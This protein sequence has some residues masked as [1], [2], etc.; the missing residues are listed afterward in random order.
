MSDIQKPV[1]FP[2]A[3]ATI[4]Q[5]KGYRAKLNKEGRFPYIESSTDGWK[6]YVN[7]LYAK[8]DDPQNGYEE[9]QFDAGFRIGWDLNINRLLLKINRFN[10]LYRFSKVMISGSDDPL[11]LMKFDVNLSGE[12]EQSFSYH[13]GFFMHMIGCFQREILDTD[14]FKGDGCGEL[15]NDALRLLSGSNRDPEAAIALYREAAA[16]GYAGSQNNLGDQYEIGK[17]LPKSNEAAIYWYTRAAERGE[18]TAYLSLAT[19]L[20][21][22]AVDHDMLLEAATFAHLALEKLPQGFNHKAAHD[23]LEL[24]KGRLTEDE[25]QKSQ[26][27]A[28]RWQPLYQERRLMS[29]TPRTSEETDFKPQLLH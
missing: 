8:D 23:C 24:L 28:T 25:L 26:D 22:I 21:E 6:F 10:Q 13:A 3:A 5:D 4:L 20:S 11:I 29:D 9:L 14:A 12:A 2:E 7:F 15:H 18:P 1:I 17:F 27:R 19:L 16:R